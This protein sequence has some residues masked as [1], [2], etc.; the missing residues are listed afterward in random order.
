MACPQVYNGVNND[1]GTNNYCIL[2][3]P[4]NTIPLMAGATN[5]IIIIIIYFIEFWTVV[6]NAHSNSARYF[7]NN[8]VYVFLYV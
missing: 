5:I 1:I 2:Y 6:S 3:N 7:K 8:P 4:L